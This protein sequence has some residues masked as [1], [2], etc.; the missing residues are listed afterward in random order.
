MVTCRRR[1]V[2]MFLSRPV[3]VGFSQK[4]YHAT[5]YSERYE[6]KIFEVSRYLT[7]CTLWK[8]KPIGAAL[9]KLFHENSNEKSSAGTYG[10]VIQSQTP[11][12]TNIWVR[13]WQPLQKPWADP[14]L[15]L[16]LQKPRKLNSI[17]DI[18]RFTRPKSYYANLM[19]AVK[20][21][22][23]PTT[24]TKGIYSHVAPQEIFDLQ[25]IFFL[26]E[27]Y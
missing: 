13:G 22:L 5:F 2:M 18:E 25:V 16:Q 20:L 7:T 23:W 26:V 8:E 27:F 10:T 24:G 21:P 3:G 9:N 14:Q 12:T 15:R 1:N 11:W 4:S 19:A 17:F 6:S